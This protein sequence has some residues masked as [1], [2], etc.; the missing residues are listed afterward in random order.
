MELDTSARTPGEIA[1]TLIALLEQHAAT[2]VS[3]ESNSSEPTWPTTGPATTAPTVS[4]GQRIPALVAEVIGATDVD[5]V[6]GQVK[7]VIDAIRDRGAEAALE[8]GKKFDGVAPDTV[9]VP[10]E[11]ID[12]A[13]AAIDTSPVGFAV[14]DR[15]L[16]TVHPAD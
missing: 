3:T 2:P 8:Y 13:L 15:V 5:A 9:R 12:Q 10:T 4:P 11:L 6:L 1:E 7:P 14:F 16:L